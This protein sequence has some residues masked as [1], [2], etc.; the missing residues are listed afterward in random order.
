M[1]RPI[2]KVAVV[3]G[4]AS[5][6]GRCAVQ[7]LL[8]QGWRVW[9]LDLSIEGLRE[10]AE[11]PE[12]ND[13]FRYAVCDVSDPVSV[14]EAFADIMSEG[15]RIHALICCAGVIRPGPLIEHTPDALQRMFGANVMGPWLC[16]RAAMPGLRRDASVEEPS[17][18]VFIGSVAGMSPKTGS[19]F[20]GAT[21]AAL[22][23]MS[24]VFAVELAPGGVTFNVVAPGTVET[25]MLG[26]VLDATAA[27]GYRPYG[28]SPLGRI[29]QPDDV[30]GAI[31]YFLGD[32]ARY[33][34]GAVLPV[35]GGTRAAIGKG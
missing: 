17:R 4:A 31:L 25:P 14:D 27:S 6:I 29:A 18:V 1:V 34:N 10:H 13:R 7:R 23:V 33:V 9:G 21:K 28:T 16:T 20:Y 30:V 2:E 22:H 12:A 26:Q 35:D 3:T 5:G 15:G 11:S 24:G 19:G 32:T 8:A